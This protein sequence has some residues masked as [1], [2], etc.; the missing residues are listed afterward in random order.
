MRRGKSLWIVASAIC[1][2]G[3]TSIFYI[4]EAAADAPASNEAK[5]AA[6]RPSLESQ[7]MRSIHRNALAGFSGTVT[8]TKQGWSSPDDSDGQPY[9][10]QAWTITTDGQG[11]VRVTIGFPRAPDTSPMYVCETNNYKWM[12]GVP[13]DTLLLIDK[14][15]PAIPELEMYVPDAA[16]LEH[17]LRQ[18]RQELRW[19]F[20]PVVPDGEVEL[21]MIERDAL[22]PQAQLRVEG[23]LRRVGFK[24]ADG[25]W[26][27][28][29]SSHDDGRTTYR[30][31]YIDHY[32]IGDRWLPKRVERERI[33]E[34]KEPSRW[35]YTEIDVRPIPRN[36]MRNAFDIPFPGTRGFEDVYVAEIYS[37]TLGEELSQQEGYPFEKLTQL[38]KLRAAGK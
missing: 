29:L 3:I 26:H 28:V 20:G 22:M 5:T 18:A 2:G 35:V 30:W 15:N 9:W 23:Q 24:F 32:R 36:D 14:V 6:T 12:T 13:S 17:R 37:R 10:V 33:D 1:L 4:F 8:F 16:F 19:L 11:N 7:V 38:G 25:L 31:T 34:G 21:L 27:P